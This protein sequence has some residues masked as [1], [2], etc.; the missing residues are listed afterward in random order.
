MM[1]QDRTEGTRKPIKFLRFIN[2]FPLDTMKSEI[3]AT[4]RKDKC[5]NVYTRYVYNV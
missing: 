3:D 5:K 2:Q 4:I 1:V